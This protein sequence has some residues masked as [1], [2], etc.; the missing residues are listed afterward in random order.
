MLETFHESNLRLTVF[1]LKTPRER[2]KVDDLNSTTY[3]EKV[4]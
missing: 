3:L 1:T 4:Q 2:A